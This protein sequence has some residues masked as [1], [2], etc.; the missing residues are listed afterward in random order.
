[1][2]ALGDN[3]FTGSFKPFK[4]DALAAPRELLPDTT[5]LYAAAMI[6][7][8]KLMA[9]IKK[10][11]A[12]S[13][14]GSVPGAVATGS[15]AQSKEIERSIETELVPARQGGLGAAILS[16][17]P[18]FDA[19]EMPAMVFAAKL[20]SKAPAGRLRIGTLFAKLR[21]VENASALSSPVVA[22]GDAGGAPFAVVT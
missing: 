5:L 9:V 17:K 2:L 15:S 1:N 13:P 22:L 8:P 11:A 7:P 20:K 3:A 14:S 21:R 12:D 6:D 18:L 10:L 4:A 19:G 16:F